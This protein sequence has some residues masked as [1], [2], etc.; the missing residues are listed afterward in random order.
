MYQ[1]KRLMYQVLAAVAAGGL[2]F[3]GTAYAA[4]ATG[5]TT[6]KVA[7]TAPVDEYALDDIV[8]T[9]ER[10]P[11][12][13]MDIPASVEVVTAETIENNHY[14][15]VAEALSHING[16]SVQVSGESEDAVRIN[17]DDR[18][19][20]LV[21][22]IRM[23]QNQG[24]GGVSDNGS[25]SFKALP[26]A[27]NIERIE[28]VRGAGSALYGSDA[29]GGVINIIT[30]KIVDNKTILDLNAGSWGTY[31]Y[32]ITNQGSDGRLTWLIDA[33][34]QRR[35]HV[36]YKMNG[37]TKTAPHSDS[38]NNNVNMRFRHQIDKE[39][40]ATLAF[41]HSTVGQNTFHNTIN[42][43]PYSKDAYSKVVQNNV[44]VGYNFKET[45]K[46]P[47]F[48]KLFSNAK[49]S[50]YTNNFTTRMYGVDYQNGWELGKDNL[51]IVGA[52]HHISKST[53]EGLG[54]NNKEIRNTAIYLQDTW[55]FAPKWSLIPGVRMDNHNMFG[56]HWTPKVALNYNA[57]DKTQ[58]YASWGR[59]FRAPTANDLYTNDPYMPGNPDLRP[60]SGHS[61]NFGIVHK[62]NK[63]TSVELTLFRTVLNDAIA[64]AEIP[65]TSIWT[66]SNVNKE[67]RRGLDI[68]FNQRISKQWS[69]NLAYSYISTRGDIDPREN[70]QPNGYR[71]GIHYQCG[72]WKSNLNGTINS[73]L[74]EQY[75]LKRNYFLL[76]FNLS[77][78]ISKQATVYF[79]ANN[80]LN[81][82]YSVFRG[83]DGNRY[84]GY[85]RF[86]QI[87][88]TYSF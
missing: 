31:N 65:G 82:E 45:T 87:G 20:V 64:W 18:I 81:Q 84:P 36:D 46:T 29:I 37:E 34:L 63:D 27:K 60:E 48:L 35:N 56:T 71:F 47:G 76:D 6:E 54:Y 40:S 79:K 39:S 10:I 38:E 22:G 30:K 59:V 70:A 9:A 55:K 13:K 15:T 28:V 16:I 75:F 57:D 51:L 42:N 83:A 14:N 73:G 11:T 3:G 8:V 53:N 7:E 26:G 78:D 52:E 19:V 41:D 25:V 33:G 80:L 50:R 32:E 72:P 86:F 85:G 49:S 5:E 61:E 43:N 12:K 68:A 17:G 69:Y 74:S 62:F 58:V 23:N 44:A 88:V 66:P 24:N 21:D 4:E 67:E 77:Y 2:C 1:K